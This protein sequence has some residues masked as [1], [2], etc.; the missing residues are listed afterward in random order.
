MVILC[1]I[2]HLVAVG[3]SNEWRFWFCV[4]KKKWSTLFSLSGRPERR[5]GIGTILPETEGR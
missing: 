4:F 5:D 2:P 1:P 3:S